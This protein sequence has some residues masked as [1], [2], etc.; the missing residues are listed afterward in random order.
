MWSNPCRFLVN[1]PSVKLSLIGLTSALLFLFKIFSFK[2]SSFSD[3]LWNSVRVFQ[4]VYLLTLGKNL[5]WL[6]YK[7]HYYGFSQFIV[8]N[9]V[10]YYRYSQFWATTV[11][12]CLV[13]SRYL[14][15]SYLRLFYCRSVYYCF[16]EFEIFSSFNYF[17]SFFNV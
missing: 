12:S 13:S 17:P 11:M 4:M 6:C 5:P 1:W 10:V 7:I 8:R 14:E 15:L 2:I 9:N 16:E 3:S